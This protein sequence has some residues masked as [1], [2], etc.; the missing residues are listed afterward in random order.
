MGAGIAASP[1]CAERRIYRCSMALVPLPKEF[2]PAT[3]SWLTSSGVA[4]HR[5]FPPKRSLTDLLVSA[6]RRLLR[7]STRL[8]WR[9]GPGF[10]RSRF[11]AKTVRCSTA[12]LGLISLA[13]RFAPSDPKILW[14]RVA[15]EED[16]LFRRH[17]PDWPASAPKS[18][19]L[20]CRRRSVLWSPAASF[21]PCGLSEEAGTAVPIT[22]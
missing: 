11:P 22:R 15:L 1:H 5:I 6:I 12:L 9:L 19:S 18:F 14:C 21:H 8:A 20:A 17:P 4:S 16:Q 2:D 13:S 7:L 3:R 10:L